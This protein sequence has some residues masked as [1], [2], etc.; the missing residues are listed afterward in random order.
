VNILIREDV[1]HGAEKEL[2]SLPGYHALFTLEP[3]RWRQREFTSHLRL[4]ATDLRQ[5]TAWADAL[6][7]ETKRPAEGGTLLARSWLLLIVGLLA[8]RYGRNDGN[9]PHLEMRLGRTLSWIDR[10]IDRTIS[11]GEL[12]ARTA[13]SE[14]T[15]L[16]RFRE[17]TGVS[18]VDYLLRARIRRAMELLDRRAVKLSISEIAS[19]CGFEDSNYFTR[20]FRRRTGKSPSE[21]LALPGSIQ[22]SS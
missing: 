2:G 17:A 15:F 9:S 12:A 14:R 11:V 19:R 13:M 6:K 18:P 7:E 10:N 4:N 20:Q 16:R 3:V 1:F 5:V 21:Y 8:R 22:I